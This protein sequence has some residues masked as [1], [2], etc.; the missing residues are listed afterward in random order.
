MRI[1]SPSNRGE[2]KKPLPALAGEEQPE[3][4]LP[5]Y[6]ERVARHKR[7]YASS[8]RY[9]APGEGPTWRLPGLQR[10]TS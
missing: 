4:P 1:G 3:N 7:V 9:G 8:T 2:R 6:G 10:T 5:V